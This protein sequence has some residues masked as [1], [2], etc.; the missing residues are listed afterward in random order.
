MI[1]TNFNV[2]EFIKSASSQSY[3]DIIHMADL[4]ATEAERLFYRKRYQINGMEKGKIIDYVQV[5]K[6]L[7]FYLR[8]GFKTKTVDI[9]TFQSFTD[10]CRKTLNGEN[11]QV[12]C[13]EALDN[14]I[15]NLK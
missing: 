10:L 11:I 4:E 12:R 8:Y 14:S 3:L 15:T 2:G 5:L 9:N 13:S 1:S 6:D 7:I